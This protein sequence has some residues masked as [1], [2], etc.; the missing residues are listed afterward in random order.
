MGGHN[1]NILNKYDYCAFRSY[2]TAD[3]KWDKWL[4][5]HLENY[6]LPSALRRAINSLPKDVKWEYTD[7]MILGDKGYLS[8]PVQLDLFEMA[9]IT[10]DVPY[11]LTQRNWTPPTW[12]YK[13]FRKR[14]VTAFSQFNDQF[15]MIRSSA[16]G[17]LHG[18]N[19]AKKPKGLF[20]RMAAKVETF[21][22]L[23]YFNLLNHRPIGQ[24]K[25]ALL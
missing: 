3:E 10:L 6:N 7:G 25:Y 20:V 11:R 17:R 22:M 2:S 19:Y 16:E 23:Q 24:V 18:K 21:R 13:R 12:A 15:M 4:H 5:K 14:I 1:K 9:N 8:A